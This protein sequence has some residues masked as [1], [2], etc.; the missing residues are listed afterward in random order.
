MSDNE[1]STS[2]RKPDKGAYTVVQGS[3]GQEYW[4]SVGA[5][6]THG[7]G[8]GETI[9]LHSFPANGEIVL[10]DLR[11][12]KMQEYAEQQAQASQGGHEQNVKQG[13][14]QQQ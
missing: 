6:W 4:N 5:A 9:K 1:E 2:N 14:E 13:Y 11:D 8:K 3:N 10:R 12:K 7:D